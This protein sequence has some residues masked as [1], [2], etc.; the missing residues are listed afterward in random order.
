MT[1]QEHFLPNENTH[2]SAF[3]RPKNMLT[4]NKKKYANYEYGCFFWWE[5]QNIALK[6]TLFSY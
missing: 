5:I 6:R 4:S 2:L 1:S 3:L